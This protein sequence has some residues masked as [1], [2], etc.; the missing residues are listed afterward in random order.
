MRLVGSCCSSGC[1]VFTVSPWFESWPRSGPS[2]RTGDLR[3]PLRGSRS[4]DSTGR[5]CACSSCSSWDGRRREVW[6]RILPSWSLGGV[7]KAALRLEPASLRS[8]PSTFP[9]TAAVASSISLAAPWN[10]GPGELQIFTTFGC[11]GNW[12]CIIL[13]SCAL[14]K[15]N[16]S[17][18]NCLY[19]WFLY[20]S[21]VIWSKYIF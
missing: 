6:A 14:L 16:N 11:W 19:K 7:T 17:Q 4:V 5:R 9:R 3:R 10:S 2:G 18:W 20:P 1:R 12:T 15:L 8:Q 13:M 21:Q